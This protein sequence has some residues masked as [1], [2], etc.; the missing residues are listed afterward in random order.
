[1]TG[2]RN[3]SGKPGG[4][5]RR[6]RL[7]LLG[8]GASVPWRPWERHRWA[9]NGPSCKAG[10]GRR[11]RMRAGGWGQKGA[12]PLPPPRPPPAARLRSVS[13]CSHGPGDA[14]LVLPE[15]P[16]LFPPE[17]GKAVL[18][19]QGTTGSVHSREG[20]LAIGA[21]WVVSEPKPRFLV[22]TSAPCRGGQA[23]GAA[24]PVALPGAVVE[25]RPEWKRGRWFGEES[26]VTG[27]RCHGS[28]NASQAPAGERCFAHKS[29][30]GNVKERV[31]V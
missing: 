30:T 20:V 27:S 13:R 31:A 24:W 16:P 17:W 3:G 29:L 7:R 18:G 12:S 5:E 11:L 22:E 4:E 14:P 10:G 23:V 9:G 8:K 28:P 2:E 1:M 26:G 25:R 19:G 15:N 6:R 21:R